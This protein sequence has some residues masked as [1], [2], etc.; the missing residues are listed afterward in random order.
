MKIRQ[1]VYWLKLGFR[2][3][4]RQTDRQ[5]L[6]SGKAFFFILKRISKASQLMLF[7]FNDTATTEIYTEHIN[8]LCGQN[9]ELLNV[10]LAVHI[11]TAGLT[12]LLICVVLM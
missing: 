1:A 11:V 10:K 3:R 6:S 5:T 7:F 4:D 9:G 12:M 2:R 8:T